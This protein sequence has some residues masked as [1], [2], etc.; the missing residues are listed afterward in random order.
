MVKE[1]SRTGHCDMCIEKLTDAGEMNG[2]VGSF[3]SMYLLSSLTIPSQK[4]TR[5]LENMTIHGAL[6]TQDSQNIYSGD[7]SMLLETTHCFPVQEHAGE[8]IA[9]ASPDFVEVTTTCRDVQM[10][11]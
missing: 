5:V 11:T 4:Y 2:F 6:R 3:F 1:F 8:Y 7:V 9:R 10:K